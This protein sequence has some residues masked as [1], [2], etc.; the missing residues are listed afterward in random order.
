MNTPEMYLDF[1]NK[2]YRIDN[3]VW[4]ETSIDN[5]HIIKKDKKLSINFYK[6]GFI[7]NFR[8]NNFTDTFTIKESDVGYTEVSNL[9]S[10]IKSKL[11]IKIID[12]INEFLEEFET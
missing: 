4:T 2:L 5:Y 12:A 8:G 10:K 6:G 3:L 11:S 9:Y 7:I 1:I